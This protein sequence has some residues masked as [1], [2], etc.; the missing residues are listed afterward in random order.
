MIKDIRKILIFKLCCFGDT[1][2]ITPAIKSLKENFP[3]AKI[4]YAHSRWVGSIINYIPFVDGDILFEHVYC[5][6]LFMKAY[7][8]L[9]FIKRA[10]KEKFDLVF[11]GHRS[12]LL[13]LIVK[14][15]S[16]KYRMGFRTTKHLTHTGIFRSEQPE[17]RRY[18]HILSENGLRVSDSPPELIASSRDTVRKSLGLNPGDKLLGIYPLGGINPGTIMPIKKWPLENFLELISLLNKELLR[19]KIIIFEGKLNEEKLSTLPGINTSVREIDND[20]ISACDYFISGDTGSLHI[21]AAMG[22]STLALFGPSNPK[23]LAPVNKPNQPVKHRYIWKAPSCSPCYT[24]D[25]AFDRRNKKYWKEK[26]FI[27]HTG[28]HECIKSITPKE[29]FAEFKKLV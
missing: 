17:F 5:K 27:C 15:C 21:A 6:N 28:T 23:I 12:N 25:T 24:T 29:V 10:R 14:A 9:K 11:F 13:S 19:L 16:I 18:L 20:L 7:G 4:I 2:F 1:V 8:T 22:V 26:N 3:D